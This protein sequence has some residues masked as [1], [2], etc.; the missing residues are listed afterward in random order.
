MGPWTECWPEHPLVRPAPARRWWRSP[1]CT[2]LVLCSVY[3]RHK[4]NRDEDF[5]ILL[6]SLSNITAVSMEDARSCLVS[7]CWSQ[8]KV[9][10]PSGRNWW[11]NCLKQ[12]AQEIIYGIPSTIVGSVVRSHYKQFLGTDK[13]WLSGEMKTDDFVLV[14]YQ[15]NAAGCPQI[16]KC[17]LWI[18]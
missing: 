17:R 13:E 6:L 9:S 8:S 10:E 5:M 12:H 4:A 15:Y 11:W 14:W 2:L 16:L 1:S 18:F 7:L 3:C